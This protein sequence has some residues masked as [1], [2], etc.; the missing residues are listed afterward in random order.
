MLF[1]Y[2]RLE[3]MATDKSYQSLNTEYGNLIKKIKNTKKDLGKGI[4][5]SKFQQQ[6]INAIKEYAGEGL[7]KYIKATI[8]VLISTLL[9][10]M[11]VG[12]CILL[13]SIVIMPLS[14]FLFFRKSI[15]LGM[16]SG[17]YTDFIL[18]FIAVVYVVLFI[19]GWFKETGG[20]Y[21]FSKERAKKKIKKL[22]ARSLII[23]KKP[24]DNPEY[25]KY[26]KMIDD[27]IMNNPEYE[28][29][30]YEFLEKMFVYDY[31]YKIIFYEECSPKHIK[32]LLE[33]ERKER[34]I[35]IKTWQ[36]NFEETQASKKEREQAEN[37]ERLVRLEEERLKEQ[38]RHNAKVERDLSSIKYKRK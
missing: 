36:K 38:K 15:S 29:I 21:Y 34:D 31:F 22:E 19:Y 14:W 7:F 33:L 8:G 10:Y 12:F 1:M 30:S 3:Y 23:I 28:C 25:L 26:K 32:E 5:I 13:A 37:L 16:Y 20:L 24:K 35:S 9:I 18:V 4:D 17:N 11:A 6:R 27:F 2:G